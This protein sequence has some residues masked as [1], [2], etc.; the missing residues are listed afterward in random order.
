VVIARLFRRADIRL[1]RV[2]HGSSYG[3]PLDAV[4]DFP[5]S[6]EGSIKKALRGI[7]RD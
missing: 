5:A 7:A 2:L 6:I 1:T 4:L 3:V